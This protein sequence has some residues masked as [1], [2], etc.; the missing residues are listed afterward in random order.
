LDDWMLRHAHGAVTAVIET[1]D[2]DLRALDDQRRDAVV[3]SFATLCRAL[4]FS[5]QIVVQVRRIPSNW[6]GSDDGRPGQ[7]DSAHLLESAMR[8]HWREHL[9]QTP[10]FSRR[11]LLLATCPD[12]SARN[13]QQSADAVVECA[14]RVGISARL[15]R[16]DALAGCF[17]HLHLPNR[18]ADAATGWAEEPR[19]A[20][21]GHTLVSGY[22]MRRLPGSAVRPGW[23][24]PLFAVPAECDVSIHMFP[25][26]MIESVSSLGRRLRGLSAQRLLDLDRGAVGDAWNDAA[27]DNAVALRDRLAR[28]VSRPLHLAMCAVARG[29]DIAALQRARHDVRAAFAATLCQIESARFRQ[30]DAFLTAAPLGRDRLLEQKLVESRSAAT[31]LPWTQPHFDDGAGYRLGVLGDNGGPV[32]VDP[33]DSDRHGNANIAII[34]AS[35][36]GKSFAIG[37]IIL[38]ALTRGT[39]AVVI[40]PEEEYRSL[41]AALG[42][43]YLALAP[44][45]GMS[46]N[47]FELVGARRD[48]RD[49]PSDLTRAETTQIVVDLVQILCG[50]SLGEVDRA[51]VDLAARRAQDR[52]AAGGRYALLGDC[53][54]E[55]DAAAPP[56]A[57][58]LRRVCSG[59]LGELFNRPTSI[60]LNA[61]VAGISFR[62]LSSEFVAAATLIVA[63]WIWGLVRDQRRQRHVIF[64]EVGIL[65]QHPPLRALLVQLARRCRKYGASLVVAT[66][67]AQDFLQTDEGM[68]VATN[69][70]MVL[71]G[72]HRAAETARME[73]AFGLTEAQ[74]RFLESAVRGEFMLI[75]GSRRARI[76]I[77]V[78][79]LHRRLLAESVTVT[80]PDLSPSTSPGQSPT[81]AGPPPR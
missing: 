19:H 50:G 4:D 43:D 74:R 11:V 45:G 29:P 49:S 30:L 52:A 67:N 33:F 13:L 21:I 25:A 48:P 69:C 6:A 34:A 27:I 70:A 14:L 3:E 60:R 8:R 40:D 10:A 18:S 17:M 64:D 46:I 28:N 79:D 12:G 5:L 78:P 81:G 31:C 44:G 41:I 20:R 51:H 61:T 16:G 75:A 35:G 56:V 37:T 55:L 59:P 63:Q 54:E 7:G 58:V 1:D 71:L 23:L 73:R 24:A 80:R 57:V 62:D 66:Q 65:G 26:S 15:L 22:I 32:R 9:S 77:R 68:V 72:G 53:L 39:P 36:H 47:V 2:L 38:E 42:G 76:R